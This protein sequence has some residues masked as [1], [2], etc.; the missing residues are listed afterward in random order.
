[1]PVIIDATEK[2]FGRVASQAAANLRGKTSP[3]FER[4]QLPTIRVKIINAARVRWSA[5]K[6]LTDRTARYSGYPG[7]LKFV[8]LDQRLKKG[9]YDG[10][11][12]STIKGMLPNNKLRDQMLKNL[13]VE[14]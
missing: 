1:M 5:K 10:V 4:N 12:R 14:E 8:T 13:T 11:F 7:G 2:F 9:G 3:T 6:R